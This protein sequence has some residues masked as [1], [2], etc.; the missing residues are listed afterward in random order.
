MI[1]QEIEKKVQD[2]EPESPEIT[3]EERDFVRIK[4]RTNY[5]SA[6]EFCQLN[7]E[8]KNSFISNVVNG[9]KKN[10]CDRFRNL[11]KTLK[12]EEEFQE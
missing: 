12:N 7:P 1:L 5:K 8:F 4:I 10:R 11:L 9:Q 2:L 3:Q 6:T